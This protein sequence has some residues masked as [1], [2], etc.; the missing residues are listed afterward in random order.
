MAHILAEGANIWKRLVVVAPA[1]LVLSRLPA[2][3][4]V[5]LGLVGPVLFPLAALVS[6]AAVGEVP[7]LKSLCSSA[8]ASL[9]KLSRRIHRFENMRSP[10]ERC[11]DWGNSTL[12][13]VLVL[14][15]V[16][17]MLVDQ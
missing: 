4:L 10:S 13:G 16:D 1:P 14:Q 2:P 12:V 3:F 8:I 6:E 15:V 5:F 9:G 11:H 17:L 7:Q